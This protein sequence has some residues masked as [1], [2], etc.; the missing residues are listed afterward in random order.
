[1]TTYEALRQIFEERVEDT[2]TTLDTTQSITIPIVEEPDVTTVMSENISE[3]SLPTTVPVATLTF[4]END[5]TSC[6]SIVS[7]S[8]G[9]DT[10]AKVYTESEMEEILEKEKSQH[11][12]SLNNIK[13]EYEKKEIELRKQNIELEKKNIESSHEYIA[14]K[15]QNIAVKEQNIELCQKLEQETRDYNL[16][17]RV[18]EKQIKELV[19]QMKELRVTNERLRGTKLKR[20]IIRED[21]N[22][23]KYTV[24]QL[25][26]FVITCSV[27]EDSTKYYAFR[28]KLKGLLYAINE[29]TN[30]SCG[31]HVKFWYVSS[32]AVKDFDK[33]KKYLNQQANENNIKLKMQRNT[34]DVDEASTDNIVELIS[35]FG[36]F[37]DMIKLDE[38]FL[39]NVIEVSQNHRRTDSGRVKFEKLNK[40]V[41]EQ[42]DEMF[43]DIYD[44]IMKDLSRLR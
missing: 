13:N 26:M 42:S 40:F 10:L 32:N 41:T 37:A 21:Y 6:S 16:R 3:S 27:N 30:T 14:V 19:Q 22:N 5:D 18:K 17:S 4:M 36:V 28:R 20:N 44:H 2:T 38:K 43:K 31:E 11:Q 35:A 7:N 29:K 1:M 25:N 39:Q 15:Q 33:C 9:N 12:Q 24:D 23:S 34:I 8:M